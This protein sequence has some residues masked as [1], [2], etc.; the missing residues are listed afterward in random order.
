MGALPKSHARSPNQGGHS[1]FFRN[2]F[3]ELRGTATQHATRYE[4]VILLP[5][6]GSRE[7]TPSSGKEVSSNVAAHIAQQGVKGGKK[8]HKQ[9]L[10]GSITT[11]TAM[12]GRRVDPVQDAP[13][14]PHAATS[15]R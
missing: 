3:E 11:T 9:H 1:N 14:P 6:Q 13:R 2:T 10:Q 4:V 5:D 15:V 12:I 7:M 8:R